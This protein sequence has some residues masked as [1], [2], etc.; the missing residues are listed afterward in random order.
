[1]HYF[2]AGMYNTSMAYKTAKQVWYAVRTLQDTSKRP[3]ALEAGLQLADSVH[4]G[5]F[6]Q[7]MQVS[8]S[9][10]C[11]HNGLKECIHQVNVRDSSARSNACWSC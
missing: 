5:R 2:V 1:M 4:L 8:T 3:L 10:S 6:P 7:V 9:V 11:H